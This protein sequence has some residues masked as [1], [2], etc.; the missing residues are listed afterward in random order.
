MYLRH[1]AVHEYPFK[2]VYCGYNTYWSTTQSHKN[3]FNVYAYVIIKELVKSY[4]YVEKH[5]QIMYGTMFTSKK[6]PVEKQ[7]TMY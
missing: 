2:C 3:I 7:Y 5:F 1:T 4:K 6:L